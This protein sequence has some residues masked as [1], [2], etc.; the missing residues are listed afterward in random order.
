V[1]FRDVLKSKIVSFAY[2]HQNLFAPFLSPPPIPLLPSLNIYLHFVNDLFLNPEEGDTSCER[3]VVTEQMALRYSRQYTCY[4]TY[5]V[6][7]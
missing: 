5:T 6:D 2:F 4:D 7:V 1:L 3:N